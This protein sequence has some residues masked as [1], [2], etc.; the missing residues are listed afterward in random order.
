VGLSPHTASPRKLINLQWL[1]LSI[2]KLT[3]EIPKEM[4][5]LTNL[6]CF[7]YDKDKLIPN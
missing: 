6:E 4:G 7:L 1:D 5:K 3:G 2:K